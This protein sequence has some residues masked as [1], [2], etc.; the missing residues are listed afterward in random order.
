MV[1]ESVLL[2]FEDDAMTRGAAIAYYAIFSVAPILVIAVAIAGYVFGA[3]A[4]QKAVETQLNEIVG[5][6][7]TEFVLSLLR[8]ASHFGSGLT[9]TLISLVGILVTASGLFSAVEASLNAILDV[10]PPRS[11][12][13]ALIRTRLL[14]VGLV[15]SVGFL[16]IVLLL[17]NTVM[18]ALQVYLNLLPWTQVV[19][20]LLN[21]GV[22]FLLLSLA[23][24]VLYRVL[25]NR[26]LSWREVM[27]GAVVTAVLLLF[28]RF[29]IS[30]YLSQASIASTYGAAGTLF[31]MLL[32][33]YYSTL[34]FL[35][36][37]E[38]VKCYARHYGGGRIRRKE[39]GD[40]ASLTAHPA[41]GAGMIPARP[42]PPQAKARS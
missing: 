34:I 3:E 31:V 40:D 36:G 20:Q 6:Q 5:P 21:T 37:A 35:F 17:A 29:G 42:I 25:P 24:G 13:W 10:P 4:A 2:F 19:L 7:A 28:G 38:C 8:S 41:E 26:W 16:L 39:K 12:V 33:I 23:I 1:K 9:A 27:V 22:S 30:L 14:G 32:W 15:I 11:T 18:A